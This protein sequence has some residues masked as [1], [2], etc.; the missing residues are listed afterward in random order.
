MPT[1]RPERLTQSRTRSASSVDILRPVDRFDPERDRQIEEDLRRSQAGCRAHS[2]V[3]SA[4][5]I[6]NCLYSATLTL[7][8]VTRHYMHAI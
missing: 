6:E 3:A 2:S 4:R 1:N 7:V 5:E 8:D